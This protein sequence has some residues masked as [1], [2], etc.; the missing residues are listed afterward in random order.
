VFEVVFGHRD[1]GMPNW[2]FLGCW[3]GVKKVNFFRFG[4]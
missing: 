4:L 1:V 2:E 3:M